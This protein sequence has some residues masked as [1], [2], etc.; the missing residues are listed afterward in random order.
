VILYAAP[1]PRAAADVP[2]IAQPVAYEA[3]FGRVVAELPAGSSAV[4][5]LVNGVSR[6]V[7]QANGRRRIALEVALPLRDSRIRVAVLTASGAR[8]SSA[9]VGPVFGLPRAARPRPGRGWLDAALQADVVRLARSFPGIVSAYVLN[10]VTGA[11]AAWNAQARF[12]AASALKLAIAVEAL[13]TLRGPP[14]HGSSLDGLLR[15]AIVNSDNRAA[16]SLE[17]LVGGSTSGGSARVN[18]LMRALGLTHTDMYGGYEVEPRRAPIPVTVTS[19]PPIS[20]TKYSSAFDLGQLM[21]DVALAADGRGPLSRRVRGFTPAEGR[22]LLYLLF[23][24]ADRGKLD[25]YLPSLAAV[26]HKAGWNSVARSDNGLVVWPG[27]G[28]VAAVMTWSPSGADESSDVLAGRI[29][30]AAF[31]R[32][33]RASAGH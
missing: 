22:Y 19:E 16:N 26:A 23:H 17:V 21:R 2:R 24:V 27:G 18:A 1:A 5:V 14:A 33:R 3:S 4:F 7:A 15:S 20:R 30:H 6:A 29:A 13:R 11:G 25:R 12:P 32:F 10:A 31:D 28:F 8:R 9:P